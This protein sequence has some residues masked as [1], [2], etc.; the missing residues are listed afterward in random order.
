[1]RN[2]LEI[3]IGEIT[4]AVEGLEWAQELYENPDLDFEFIETRISLFGAGLRNGFNACLPNNFN[5]T[6][7]LIP[8]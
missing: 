2:N 5:L 3:L 4:F 8:K 1:M 7:A 6:Q